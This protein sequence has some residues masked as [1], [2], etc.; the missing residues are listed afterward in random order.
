MG[1]TKRGILVRFPVGARHFVFFQIVQTFSG[2]QAVSPPPCKRHRSDCPLVKELST[3]SYCRNQ[4][5]MDVYRHPPLI[6]LYGVAMDFACCYAAVLPVFEL[7]I[8]W[9]QVHSYA[10]TI[11]CSTVIGCSDKSHLILNM[12]V[13]AIHRQERCS[14]IACKLWLWKGWAPVCGITWAESWLHYRPC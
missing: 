4:E 11:I 5:W 7:V 14:R 3:S 1:G 9:P 10:A 8:S 13:S 2:A 12:C 6:R